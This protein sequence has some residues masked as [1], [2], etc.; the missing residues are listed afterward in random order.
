M[1]IAKIEL[2]N[3]KGI[4]IE[5]RLEPLTIIT[6]RN[7]SGKTAV[8]LGLKLG[9]IGYLPTLGKSP[10]PFGFLSSHR[11]QTARIFPS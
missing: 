3:V 9:L 8:A 6:G 2:E 4:T 1:R 7:G 11:P 5:H 10:L